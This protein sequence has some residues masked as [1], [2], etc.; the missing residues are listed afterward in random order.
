MISGRSFSALAL[1]LALLLP[2]PAAP[3]ATPALP[4]GV[5]A[6]PS[7][8]G[9]SEYTLGNGLR[10]L[11]LPEHTKPTATVN[12]TYGVG[13]VQGQYGQTSMADQLE[14]SVGK[15]TP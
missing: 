5:T 14:H 2:G 7:I 6:G 8:E 3:A 13:S 15:G 1:A 11:L 10:V 12:L 9:I 4:K